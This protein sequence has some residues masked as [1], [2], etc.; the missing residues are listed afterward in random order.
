MEVLDDK[1][2]AVGRFNGEADCRDLG[3]AILLPGLI[4]A[5]THLE[6][7]DLESPLGTSGNTITD[8]IPQV[9]SNRIAKANSAVPDFEVAIRRG[10]EEC[11]D[12]GVVHVG[13]IATQPDLF[14]V[15][16]QATVDSTVFL[17]RLGASAERT[18][19]LVESA[20]QF[21]RDARNQTDPPAWRP[22]LSPH[23][24]YSVHPGLLE[25]LVALS[26]TS[27]TVVA[28]HVAETREELEWIENRSG[29]F[30]PLLESLGACYPEEIPSNYSV[31]KVLEVL[32][33]AH[34]CLVVHGNYLTVE[35]MNWVAR[36][37]QKMSVVYCPRTHHYFQHEKYPLPELLESGINV[38]LG[39]DSR[40][41]NPDLNLLAEAQHVIETFDIDFAGTIPLITFNAAVALGIDDQYG[42]IEPGKQAVFSVIET[43][44]TKSLQQEILVNR[45]ASV[46]RVS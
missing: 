4:N 42:T 40:A 37:G 44:S 36:H 17:E 23:A 26:R 11:H 1:I 18:N 19:Q 39:T 25:E 22:G 32:S 10:M 27:N 30:R 34:R 16:D 6:F 31:Q 24:P 14:S 35:N 2:V 15:Y 38:A 13:E 9:I 43:G 21:I 5:H 29:P 7:S 28:M 20:R 46:F 3:D 8:W 12:S 45:T 33:G 41:S